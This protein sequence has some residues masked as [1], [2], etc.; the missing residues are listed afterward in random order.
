[1]TYQPP[2]PERLTTGAAQMAGFRFAQPGSHAFQVRTVLGINRVT[3]YRWRQRDPSFA[4]AYFFA[5]GAI[6]KD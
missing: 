4:Q 6:S 5:V 1:M 3:V 2:R